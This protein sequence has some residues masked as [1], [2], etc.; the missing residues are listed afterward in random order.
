LAS[1]IELSWK[2]KSDVL[3]AQMVTKSI[4][5]CSINKVNS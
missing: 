3:T 4:S 5:K 1:R 2:I